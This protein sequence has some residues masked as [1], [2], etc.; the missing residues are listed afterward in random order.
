VGSNFD[1]RTY[2]IAD[3]RE[4]EKRFVFDQRCSRLEDGASY[5]G[6]IGVMPP[7]IA[8]WHDL[9]LKSPLEAS[10]WLAERHDKYS[11]AEAVSF[12]IPETPTTADATRI[13]EA[14]HAASEANSVAWRL[15]VELLKEVREGGRGDYV[16]C[17]EC[18]SALA[19]KR[20]QSIKCPLCPDET[21]QIK[22]DTPVPAGFVVTDNV[23][24][25]IDGDAMV[26]I[27]KSASLLL[28]KA[29]AARLSKTRH[30]LE[31]ARAKEVEARAPRP[32]KNVGWLVGGWCSS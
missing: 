31:E 12:F 22:P 18:G 3:R 5:S 16:T 8:K 26:I 6:A 13:R 2:G 14:A 10:N 28:T 21:R 30:S 7:G 9:K 24:R 19:R 15:E 25:D 27:K 29:Q 1:S 23:E 11:R 4:V 32:S 20:L 17:E